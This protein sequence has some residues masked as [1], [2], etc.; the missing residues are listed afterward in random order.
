M[1]QICFF[2]GKEPFPVWLNRVIVGNPG[3]GKTTFVKLYGQLLN[4][5]NLLSN[6]DTVYTT[7]N[8]FIGLNVG[9]TLEKAKKVIMD[10]KGKVLAIDEA[11]ILNEDELG[12]KVLKLSFINLNI[13]PLKLCIVSLGFCSNVISNADQGYKVTGQQGLSTNVTRAILINELG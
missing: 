2:A 4:H 13:V 10:A 7:A 12:R 9:Q 6:G 1:F 8:D 11:Y 5:L 3:T